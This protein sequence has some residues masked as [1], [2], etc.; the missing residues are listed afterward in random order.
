LHKLWGLEKYGLKNFMFYDENIL[1]AS[2]RTTQHT[3]LG[4]DRFDGVEGILKMGVDNKAS[5]IHL[6]VGRAPSFRINGKMKTFTDNILSPEDTMSYA[7][8]C[9]D[10]EKLEHLMAVEKLIFQ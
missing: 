1:A 9:L 5:D 2:R 4:D 6:T 8:E 10:K 7:K 3:C